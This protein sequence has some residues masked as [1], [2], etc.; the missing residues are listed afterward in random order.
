MG[1]NNGRGNRQKLLFSA[2]AVTTT[3]FPE[4]PNNF[5]CDNSVGDNTLWLVTAGM[6]HNDSTNNYD[7]YELWAEVADPTE[8]ANCDRIPSDDSMHHDDSM[9]NDDNDS[10]SNSETHNNSIESMVIFDPPEILGHHNNKPTTNP[11]I[12]IL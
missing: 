11:N 7:E 1:K 5:F 12:T 4:F 6:S 3:V 8:Y 9:H 2:A 10:N